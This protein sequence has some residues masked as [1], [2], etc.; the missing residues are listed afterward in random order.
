MQYRLRT[1]LFLLAILPPL[2]APPLAFVFARPAIT[3]SL[4]GLTIF[5]I[6]WLS[7]G[8]LWLLIMR[9]FKRLGIM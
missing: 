8:V 5:A 9:A 2:I 1:M 3:A 4:I 7:C 6:F